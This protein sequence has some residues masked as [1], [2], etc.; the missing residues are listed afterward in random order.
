MLLRP[1]CAPRMLEARGPA[2]GLL[3]DVVFREEQVDLRSGDILLLYTD[4]VTEARPA[5]GGDPFD[6]DRLVATLADCHGLGAD[7]VVDRIISTVL[8]Y[9]DGDTGDDTAV[10]VVRADPAP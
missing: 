8:A 6:D 2:L 10:L 7:A 1:G 5:P 9:A 4:G 3:P